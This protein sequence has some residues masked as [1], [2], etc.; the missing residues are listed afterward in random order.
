MSFH[1]KLCGDSFI[2]LCPTAVYGGRA[3]GILVS[4]NPTL[5]VISLL[6]LIPMLMMTTDFG[7]RITRLFTRWIS[8]LGTCLALA[9]NVTGVQVVRAFAREPYEVGRFDQ[10]NKQYFDARIQVMNEWSKVMP[11]TTYSSRSARS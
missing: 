8:C 6:P 10:I 1:S 4:L 7:E 3:I 5:A 11:T 9:E 2:Q